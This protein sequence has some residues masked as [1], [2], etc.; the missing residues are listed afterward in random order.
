MH[1]DLVDCKKEALYGKPGEKPTRCRPHKTEDMI[2]LV[3]LFW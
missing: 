1:C 3:F 2:L